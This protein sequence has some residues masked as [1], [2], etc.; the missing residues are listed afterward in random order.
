MDPLTRLQLA[1]AVTSRWPTLHV[2]T[3]AETSL[4]TARA[5]LEAALGPL[6][7]ADEIEPWDDDDWELR[8]AL[9][10]AEVETALTALLA[11]VPHRAILRPGPTPGI[12]HDRD[13]GRPTAESWEHEGVVCELWADF[14]QGG[15]G[16]PDLRRA[17]P[18]AELI[19]LER[20]IVLALQAHGQT[21]CMRTDRGDDTATPVVHRPS[22][23]LGLRLHFP[24][25]Q[26]LPPDAA[27]P[28]LAA[29]VRARAEHPRV[30]LAPDLR[31]DLDAG[32]GYTLWLLA[33]P[34]SGLPGD[35]LS[36]P[37]RGEL[38]RMISGLDD[39]APRLEL[40]VV[41]AGDAEQAVAAVTELLPGSDVLF[42]DLPRWIDSPPRFAATWR[43]AT[44]ALPARALD[45]WLQRLL[46]H[47][48]VAAARIV[49]AAPHGLEESWRSLEPAWRTVGDTAF[50]RLRDPLLDRDH[51]PDL[52]PAPRPDW[53][54]ALDELPGVSSTTAS[55][56]PDGTAVVH[57]NLT[58]EASQDPL[59]S[60]VLAAV[61]SRRPPQAR[62]VV[63][64]AFRGD[65]AT[66]YLSE[67]RPSRAETP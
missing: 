64:W 57:L 4:L 26:E 6:P 39:A 37:A 23:R 65:Q 24:P 12:V 32:S 42:G 28:A 55:R 59:L 47:P 54:V 29:V 22:G 62:S 18:D 7:Q 43:L 63:W 48:A 25:G 49:P 58:R 13:I 3:T 44:D 51:H 35:T 10:G 15:S 66:L 61:A 20:E 45:D 67:R 41:A 27:L 1:A 5:A 30:R 52:T 14:E 38:S 8:V 9:P 2:H 17:E 56:A 21:A 31:Y 53:A 60:T 36:P 46:T 50:L 11:A 16:L 34:V 40:Q 19:E 33:P